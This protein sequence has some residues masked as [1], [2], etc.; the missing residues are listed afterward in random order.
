[1]RPKR[2]A[3]L[4]WG[5][6]LV[7]LIGFCA[8]FG[9][10]NCVVPKSGPFHWLLGNQKYYRTSGRYACEKVRDMHL[11]PVDPNDPSLTSDSTLA[12][13]SH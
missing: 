1:M 13:A 12:N 11:D 4:A 6:F 5:A 10:R 7:I 3:V 8:L 2:G 9:G